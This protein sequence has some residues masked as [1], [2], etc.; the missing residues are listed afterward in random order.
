MDEVEGHIQALGDKRLTVRQKAAHA[1]GKI[2]DPRAV[3]P[4]FAALRDKDCFVSKAAAE[5]LGK[6]GD[7]RAVEPLI[8]ALGDKF[9]DVREAAARAL[10]KIGEPAVERLKAAQDDENPRIRKRAAGVLKRISRATAKS[11]R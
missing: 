2:G 4:L 3:E 10:V 9:S 6:I 7:A 8:A 11:R 5:A 1:L